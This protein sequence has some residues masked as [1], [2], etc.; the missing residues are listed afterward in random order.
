M[1]Q[2]EFDRMQAILAHARDELL[3]LQALVPKRSGWDARQLIGD[4]I[5][6]L[7]SQIADNVYDLQDLPL[8]GKAARRRANATLNVLREA[9][10]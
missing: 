7:D 5:R 6:M 4:A 10:A 2:A 3:Q 8:H 1:T 9:D